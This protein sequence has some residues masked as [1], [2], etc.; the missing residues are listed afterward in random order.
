MSSFTTMVR[1]E[2]VYSIYKPPRFH[3]AVLLSCVIIVDVNG[4]REVAQM[5]EQPHNNLMKSIRNYSDILDA[6]N[7]SL[8]D[9]FIPSTYTDGNS[10]SY[11]CY[12][13]TKK[14]CDIVANKMAGEKG[15]IFTA[16]YV[17]AFEKNARENHQ[18]HNGNAD[19]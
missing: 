3:G 9:F 14:G 11:P 15:I 2:L 16:M 17:S 8:V 4:S 6:G 1:S 18:A 12:L 10:E 5:I 13:L 19:A 7:F